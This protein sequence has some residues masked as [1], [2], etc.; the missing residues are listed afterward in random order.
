MK[1]QVAIAA[2]LLVVGMTGSAFAD[3]PVRAMNEVDVTFP[4]DMVSD[5]CG[6]HV[7]LTIRGT[8]KATLIRDSDGNVLREVAT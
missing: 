7:F 3:A 8:F 6:F 2:A 1:R 4:E 5:A